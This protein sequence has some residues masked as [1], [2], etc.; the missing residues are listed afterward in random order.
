[1]E[2]EETTANGVPIEIMSWQVLARALMIKAL[3]AMSNDD[4]VTAMEETDAAMQTILHN[5]PLGDDT[6]QPK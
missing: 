5:Y 1:M 4:W 3:A 6:C 2:L